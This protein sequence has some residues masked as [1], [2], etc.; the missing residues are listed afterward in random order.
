MKKQTTLLA[1]AISA[2]ISLPSLA[3]E[4]LRLVLEYKPGQGAAV[5]SALAKKGIEVR[6]ELGDF[7]SLAL[8]MTKE[9]L[10][11]LKSVSGIAQVY[12]DTPRRMLDNG[13]VGE[14]SPYG[15]AMTQANQLA[16]A[17]GTK[18]CIIDSGYDYGHADLPAANVNGEM[19]LSGPWNQDDHS[20][21]THV[22]GTIAALG[23]GE[24]V[25]GVNS[26][27]NMNLHIVRVFNA[28]G[29]FAYAS[30]LAGAMTDCAAAGANVISMSLGGGLENPLEEK[31]VEKM[32]RDGM[33]L[34][35]AAGNDANATHSY[36]ASYDGVMS[37]AAIDDGARHAEFSQRTAQVEIA[38]PGVNTLSTVPRGMGVNGV[39]TV[40]QEDSSYEAIPMVGA[41]TGDIS[42][43]LA[44]C[45]L[46][47][48]ACENVQDS[49]C[50]IERG[51]VSF[52]IKVANCEAGGGIGAIVYNNQP[53]NF[54]G[55]L[56]GESPLVAV[57]V[58]Q[59]DGQALV[60]GMEA[61]ISIAPLA[62]YDYKSGTS[63]ATPH[64]SGVAALV[65]SH[66]PQCTGADIRMALRASAKDL[67]EPGYD[68]Q[69]GW[70]LVQ[71][72]ATYDYLATNGC[73]V[74]KGKVYGGDGSAR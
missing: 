63:M 35:A 51:E 13:G 17:G 30:D 5:K 1:A 10:G 50:L 3:S 60:D 48:A 57:S 69:F 52:G 31:V 53:G 18:V 7:D 24:G 62:D 66:F 49:I 61:S 37:V 46:G 6:R 8:T 70:G 22:A 16:Y 4:P 40:S 72:K 39:G 11:E 41:T 44:D 59:A 71:A 54:G 34:I 65:W 15:I 67:G 32:S 68:Y 2:A 58:S 73:G 74:N 55:D 45:G 25:V 20:H 23:N 43:P 36:P 38:G 28:E 33:L 14:I 56:G 19:G 27:A 9:Q 12:P 21:G 29:S 47:S 64:V 42:A 26:D